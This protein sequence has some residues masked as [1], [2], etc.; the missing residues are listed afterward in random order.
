VTTRKLKRFTPIIFYSTLVA[1]LFPATLAFQWQSIRRTLLLTS[2]GFLSWQL[3]EYVL[4]RFLFHLDVQ[5]ESLR[6]FIYHA[7]LSHHDNPQAADKLFSSLW[8]SVPVASVY[9]LLAWLLLGKWETAVYLWSGLV[10]GYLVYEWVHYQAHH[11]R[12]RIVLLRYLKRYHL[13]HHHT[14]P[15]LRFGVTSPAFDYLFRT[16]RSASRRTSDCS[17]SHLNSGAAPT[18]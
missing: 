8:L 4:H 2:I 6:R 16:Y 17:S 9:F 18:T 15:A 12:S 1:C 11:G 13:L 14:T 10:A 3:L 7:H 5:S